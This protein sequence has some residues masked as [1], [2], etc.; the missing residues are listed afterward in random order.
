MLGNNR[1]GNLVT[2]SR[3]LEAARKRL[4]PFVE[5]ARAFTGWGFTRYG[6]ARFLGP[7]NPWAYDR[8][9]QELLTS[10]KSVLDIGTGG[11]ERLSGYLRE[12]SGR[13]VTTEAWHVNAPIAASRL[14]PLA[15]D[16]L[17]CDDEALPLAGSSFD[18]IINRHAALKPGDIARILSPG[19]TFLTEQ[20]S[21]AHWGELQ[22]FFPRTTAGKGDI[23]FAYLVGLRAAGLELTDARE[24]AV[25]AAYADLGNLVYML[26]V[27]PW[28][29]P[30]FDPLGDD[31]EA[32]LELERT[33]STS[34][35]L[36][37]T[38]GHSL[39]EAKKPSLRG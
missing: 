38:Q 22:A 29:I 13:G 11:G 4:R 24:Y 6:N 32:L 25:L 2:A 33:L 17:Y 36:V 30:D 5:A 35:G 12:Y 16:V 23:Y 8:R 31:L 9:V 10:A 20:I 27:T 28:T 14:K 7:R 34:D 37:L 39:I 26:C 1:V 3:S 21:N 18:L 15:V 19:G